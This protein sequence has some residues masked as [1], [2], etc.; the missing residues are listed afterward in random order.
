MVFI[1]TLVGYAEIAERNIT[2]NAVKEAVGYLCFLKWL[3]R[4]RGTLIELLCDTCGDF[5][6][7]NAI[8]TAVL[9]T[10]RQHTDKVT[11]TAGRLQDIAFLK[12]HLCHRLVDSGDHNRRRVKCR[13]RAFSCGVIFF[14]R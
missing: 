11:D 9:H 8:Y 5:I 14:G 6:N 1:V 12:A 10:L 3:C 2:D 13:Q 7:L 4:N